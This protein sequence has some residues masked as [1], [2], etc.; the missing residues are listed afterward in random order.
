MS[1]KYNIAVVFLF[2]S[3]TG[4]VL[5]NF[6]ALYDATN[7]NIS[8]DEMKRFVERYFDEPGKEFEDWNPND[9]VE[10]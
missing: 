10:R 3:K 8:S 6:T 9:W 4:E 2:H 7:G 5:A 1:Y